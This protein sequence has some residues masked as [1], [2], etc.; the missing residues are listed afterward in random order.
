MG[1][2]SVMVDAGKA[3]AAAPLGPALGPSGVNIGKVVA[4][5]NE[6]TKQFAGMKIPVKIN[7]DSSKGFTITV[8]APP[9]SALI[10]KELNLQILGKNQKTDQAGNLTF[11]QLLKISKMKMENMGSYELKA[12]VRELVGSCNSSGIYIEGI[13]AKDFQKLLKAGKYDSRIK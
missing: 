5:I 2:I 13:H 7:I 12:S 10:K 11:D 3:T 8:G 6:K 4:E 1:E 9:T